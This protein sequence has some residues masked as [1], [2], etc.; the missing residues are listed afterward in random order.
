VKPNSSWQILGVTALIVGL[1]FILMAAI[2]Q[3]RLQTYRREGVAVEARI[4]EKSSHG[5]GCI[6]VSFFDKDLLAGGELYLTEICDF[7][8]D[9]L[10]N[11]SRKGSHEMVVYL[12]ADPQNHTI[13][14][15]SLE[16]NQLPTFSIG[17]IL[18]GIS[19]LSLGWQWIRNKQSK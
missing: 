10:W 11:A 16:K 3:Q 8:T 1:G 15:A 6:S 7:V 2:N 5:G 9:D 4:T 18:I 19:L 13:F 14:A 17:G 12:P